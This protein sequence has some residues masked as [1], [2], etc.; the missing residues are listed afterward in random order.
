MKIISTAYGAA[1]NLLTGAN[2][3]NR[4]L[5]SSFPNRAQNGF[6]FQLHAPASDLVF[7]I[8]SSNFGFASDSSCFPNFLPS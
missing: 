3:G 7:F 6:N 8:S 1:W 2:R 5:A 4:G